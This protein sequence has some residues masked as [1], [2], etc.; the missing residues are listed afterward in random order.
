VQLRGGLKR[1]TVNN[2]GLSIAE[3]VGQLREEFGVSP[4]SESVRILRRYRVS[5]R[6]DVWRNGWTIS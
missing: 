1:G 4:D 6:C 3:W 2:E 5:S